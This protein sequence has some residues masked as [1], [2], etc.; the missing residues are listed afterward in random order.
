MLE[1]RMASLQNGPELRGLQ[2][3]SEPLLIK[4]FNNQWR[5]PVTRGVC[6]VGDALMSL[7][8]FWG[9]GCGFSL[10]QAAWL[11]DATSA[12]L[13]ARK[14]LDAARRQYAG[15]VRRGHGLHRIL[16]ND[17][18]RRHHLNWLE[19][20]MFT[21]ATRDARCAQHVHAFGA[22]LITPMQFI[23]PGALFRAAWVNVTQP[24]AVPAAL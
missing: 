17:F 6:F 15:Q 1:C 22:R 2:R 24:G 10:Q 4:K 23:S 16:I 21:A 12:A 11:V 7:D 13:G 19:R 18:S 3:L 9:T 14:G 8:Y 5:P 20:M